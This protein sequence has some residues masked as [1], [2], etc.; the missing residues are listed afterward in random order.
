M[1]LKIRE[2]KCVF[3]MVYHQPQCWQQINRKK[4]LFAKAAAQDFNVVI[5]RQ[6]V[7][8]ECFTVV[9]TYVIGTYWNKEQEQRVL[10]PLGTY[11]D[12]LLVFNCSRCQDGKTTNSL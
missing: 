6:K 8:S 5:S 4:K 9:D 7:N 1:H 11:Q 12:Q 3:V 2:K 10:C